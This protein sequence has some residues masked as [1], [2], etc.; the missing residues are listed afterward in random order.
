M[1]AG[2]GTGACHAPLHRNRGV[3]RRSV[4]ASLTP[5]G[6][7]IAQAAPSPLQEQFHRELS[8]LQEWEQTQMLATLQ[9]IASMMDADEID[10]LPSSVVKSFCGVGNPLALGELRP[11]QTVLDIGS[12]GGLD[13]ILAA[14]TVGPSGRVIGIDMTQEMVDRAIGISGIRPISHDEGAFCA[15]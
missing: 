2:R 5:E 13:S 6:S 10:A 9:R 11:G 4:L 8:R 14:R 3:D 12:G 1:L 15:C 7:R